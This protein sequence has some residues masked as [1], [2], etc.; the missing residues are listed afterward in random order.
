MFTK[1][2]AAI[3]AA[4]L[5]I[6]AF[7][8][9]GGGFLFAALMTRKG[10]ENSRSVRKRNERGASAT[11]DSRSWWNAKR[12]SGAIEE[13]VVTSGRVR[14]KGYLVPPDSRAG[15]GS[16]IAVVLLHGYADCAAGVSYLAR[17][18]HLRGAT[19]LSADCRASGES[20]GQV[21]GMGYSDA[22]DAALW[23]ELLDRRLE[24][25]ARIVVHGVSTG[26]VAAILLAERKNLSPEKL[27][28]VVADCAFASEKSLLQEMLRTVFGAGFLRTQAIRILVLGMSVVSFI[29]GGFFL[30]Q[31]SPENALKKRA[32]AKADGV[33][34][35]L[36][37]GSRDADAGEDAFD[38]LVKAAGGKN[39]IA[40]RIEGAGRDGCYFH[41]P[42][43]YMRTIFSALS[44]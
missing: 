27:A 33:P 6:F 18:Y 39:V 28:A 20:E 2:C 43:Q 3:A 36:F 29:T 32:R 42:E 11:E 30:F 12:A 44:G 14:L 41:A 34:L 31:N 16:D 40:R 8:V 9:S 15:G 5:G 24:G 23:T 19:V 13:L 1:L 22:K 21:V 26:A 10:I 4:G 7:A 38:R 35:V 25:R 37:H 17:E